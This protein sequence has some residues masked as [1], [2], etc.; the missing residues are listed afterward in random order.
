MMI[1]ML[2]NLVKLIFKSKFYV[3][4]KIF[5]FSIK[6]GLNISLDI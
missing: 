4:K 2:I 3:Q 1:K 5:R 6:N